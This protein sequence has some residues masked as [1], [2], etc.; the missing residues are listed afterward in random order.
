MRVLGIDTSLRSTGVGV[1]ESVG[2]SLRAVDFRVLR[3][4]SALR[5]SACLL[6]I[7]R[8]I[9]EIIDSTRPD[10]AAIE[11]AFFC[12]NARTS[13]VLGEAR[14]VAIAACAASGIPVFEY[15]PR[16]VKQAVAG[17]G[18]ASKEQIQAMVSRLLGLDKAPAADA[19]DA[20]ALAV[21]HINGL[22]TRAIYGEEDGRV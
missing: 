21:C 19:A 3:T 11:G 7:D 8:G 10:A 15:A 20:L 4:G 1:V 22:S 18:A 17:F 2:S 5:V 16:R 6:A 14:G 12:K 9:R 13:M